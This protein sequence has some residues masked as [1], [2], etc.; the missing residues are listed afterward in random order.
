MSVQ[1]FADGLIM[2]GNIDPRLPTFDKMVP[3]CQSFIIHEAC[4]QASTQNTWRVL[5]AAHTG[6]K[7]LQS[8]AEPELSLTLV[9]TTDFLNVGKSCIPLN[10]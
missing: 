4:R 8:L 9:S 3:S 5:H 6:K 2:I 7:V 1:S 10:Y